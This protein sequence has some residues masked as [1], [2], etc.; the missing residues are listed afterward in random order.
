MKRN[1][2]FKG[3]YA[4]VEVIGGVLLL[5]IAVFSVVFIAPYLNPDL[6]PIDQNI[7]LMGYVDENGMAIIEHYGGRSFSNYRIIVRDINGTL[8]SSNDYH[9]EWKL[10]Q[11][12][13]PLVY[14]GYGPLV[15][16]NDYVSI[17]VIDMDDPE[18]QQT[19]FNGELNG[20][21]I[22]YKSHCPILISSYDEDSPDEDL[23]C[24]S[25]PVIP[26]INATTY[27]YNW[28]VNN[29]PLATLIMPFDTNSSSYT[30]DYSGHGLDGFVR[31]CIWEEDGVVGGCYFFGGSKEYI[32]IE[33]DLP[34]CFYNISTNDFT[35][36]IWV[37]SNFMDEDNKIIYEIR[38][39]TKNYVRLYQQNDRFCFGVCTD[40]MK[41]SVVSGSVLSNTWYH[42]GAVWD[43]DQ[44][45]LEIYLDGVCYTERGDTSFSCGSHTGLS[46]GHGNSGSGGYWFG[47]LDELEVYDYI[48]SPYQIYQI[49]LSQKSGQTDRRV[50]VSEETSLGQVWQ[51]TV[52]PNDG[53]QD[54]TP[55]DSN[56]LKIINYQGGN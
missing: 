20:N 36:S 27:I 33:I 43:A 10:G 3:S 38:K 45:Y 21:F 5:G 19:V 4:V 51:V 12:R 54:G 32:S 8:I 49:Y 37:K 23:I 39:D 35:I 15:D 1:T 2:T 7:K 53:T 48:L 46:L 55:I 30:K 34:P 50:F 31:D 22:K 18:N 28:K 11:C 47:Y 16:Q 24:Y 42:V 17:M 9:D 14:I 25:Y 41:K 26:D 13:Y 52:T 40:T 56:T 44:E 29:K 6:P